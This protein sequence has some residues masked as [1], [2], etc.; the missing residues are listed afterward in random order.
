[1][2]NLYCY[3]LIVFLLIQ[4]SSAQINYERMYHLIPTQD[5]FIHGSRSTNYQTEFL[6]I[7]RR[8]DGLDSRIL[9]K[10]NIDEFKEKSKWGSE[11]NFTNLD[12]S[13]VLRASL[14]LSCIGVVDY[15]SGTVLESVFSGVV[16]V[17][18]LLQSW[19]QS[20]VTSSNRNVGKVW[21]AEGVDTTG[22]DATVATASSKV[23]IDYFTCQSGVTFQINIT[24]IFQ[25]WLDEPQTNQGVMVWTDLAPGMETTLKVASTESGYVGRHPEL[26]V[27]LQ[28]T[29]IDSGEYY[30]KGF[31]HIA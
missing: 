14:R 27:L 9:L 22:H 1:M 21:W 12:N 10:F 5:T 15:M 23:D 20:A 11:G 18:Q 16:Q 13:E 6:E 2:C 4:V 30:N 3:V 7:G 8:G 24:T 25:L 17:S 31:S 19:D 26:L 28:D 29:V